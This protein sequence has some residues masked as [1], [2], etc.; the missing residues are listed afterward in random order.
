MLQIVMEM[1]IYSFFFT[2]V[3]TVE[4]G[5]IIKYSENKCLPVTGT[6]KMLAN[7]QECLLN[8]FNKSFLNGTF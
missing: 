2:S 5:I 3:V 6:L 8:L 1:R 7:L 4:L